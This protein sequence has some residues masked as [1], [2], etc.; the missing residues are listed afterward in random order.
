MN[1]RKRLVEGRANASADSSGRGLL[2]A[3]SWLLDLSDVYRSPLWIYAL[4]KFVHD[5]FTQNL[6]FVF[7]GWGGEY[8]FMRGRGIF[9]ICSDILE[10][11]WAE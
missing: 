1:A 4:I 7:L 5:L 8:F 2:N 3:H 6:F 10:Q 9:G 11:E